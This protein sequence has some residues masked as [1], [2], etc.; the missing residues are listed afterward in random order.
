ME[1]ALQAKELKV[2]RG[3]KTVLSNLTFDVRKGEVFALL[4]GNGAGKSTTLLTFMGLLDPV[5][6]EANVLGLSA[7]HEAISV[8]SHIAYLP[9]SAALYEHLTAIENLNYF[10]S[11]S[12]SRPTRR[13]L[14]EALDSVSL[15]EEN[16]TQPLGSYSKGMRQKVAI[17]LALLRET[18]ILLLDEPTSGLDPAAVEDFHAVLMQLAAQGVTILMVTHDLYGVC[19]VADRVGLL[20]DGSLVNIFESNSNREIDISLVRDSFLGRKAA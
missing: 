3:A 4:G 6:G 16:R 5:T 15:P 10:L 8:R 17:A 14:F 12:Q 11:L 20:H 9:E 13:E 1:I 2:V 18:P 19:Q 7:K